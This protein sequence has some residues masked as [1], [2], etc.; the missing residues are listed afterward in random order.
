M[1][2][3]HIVVLAATLTGAAFAA[4]PVREASGNSLE[5]RVG[6][7]E[8]MLESRNHVQV[9]MQQQLSDLEYEVGQL[10]G[11]IEL[12]G[13]QL[14]QILARQRD[15]YQ[16][17]ERRL[18]GSSQP[19]V[20]PNSPTTTTPTE[21]QSTIE[22]TAN[23]AYEAAFDLLKAKRYDQ[24]VTAFSDF[25]R[26]Y[27]TSNYAANAYYWQAQLKFRE[28]DYASAKV[29]FAKVVDQYP[30]SSKRAESIFKLGLIAEK[31][32]QAAEARTYFERVKNEYPSSSVAQLA[33][34]K[35]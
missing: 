27:P 9:E 12:H 17:I 32:G 10:R 8:R 35:L 26:D 34:G 5:E 20:T 2:K 24:A 33:K 31:E 29:S 6:R 1:M 3:R 18:T 30:K 11:S 23:V 21:P 25:I 4:A 13:H 19:A 15:L 14:E 16:D 28:A 22:V 7:L